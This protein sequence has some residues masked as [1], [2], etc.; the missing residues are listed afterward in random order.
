MVSIIQFIYVFNIRWSLPAG[1][2]TVTFFRW[3]VEPLPSHSKHG[4][5][6]Y[7]LVPRHLL[8]VVLIMKGPVLTV[9]IP[10]PLQNGHLTALVPGSLLDPRHFGQV[11]TT[12]KTISLLTPLAASENFRFMVNCKSEK[13]WISSRTLQMSSQC[14]FILPEQHQ[15]Q[16]VIQQSHLQNWELGNHPVQKFCGIILQDQRSTG[17]SNFD[18][19]QSLVLL[20]DQCDLLP[21]VRK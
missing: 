15:I 2:G 4:L 3:T 10:V 5:G 14:H 7:I 9:S 6:M 17:S 1:T 21:F 12:F 13:K 8:H 18:E 20:H 16:I 11:S 19:H